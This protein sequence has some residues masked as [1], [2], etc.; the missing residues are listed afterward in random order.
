MH[1]CRIEAYARA[2]VG[3][4]SGSPSPRKET[5]RCPASPRLALYISGTL[6]FFGL[7]F[8]DRM[9]GAGRSKVRVT[10]ELSL[11]S[12]QPTWTKSSDDW[13]ASERKHES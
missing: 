6:L 5:Q 10:T 4:V 11:R 1:H 9:R 2:E 7:R 8:G 12:T 3:V 13:S